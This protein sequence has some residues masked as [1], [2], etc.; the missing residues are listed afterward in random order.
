MG[1]G[2]AVPRTRLEPRTSLIARS[3]LAFVTPN[4]PMTRDPKDGSSTAASTRCSI[5]T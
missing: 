4:W 5:E 2:E 1:S 3:S